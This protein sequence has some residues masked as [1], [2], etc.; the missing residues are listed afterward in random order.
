MERNYKIEKLSVN[1]DGIVNSASLS[2][3]ISDKKDDRLYSKQ[4]L[5]KYSKTEDKNPVE[6]T[7]DLIPGVVNSL[8][9]DLEDEI[10]EIEKHISEREAKEL[11]IEVVVTSE[12]LLNT[13]KN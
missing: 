9:P 6:I 1:I 13:T 7:S 11:G 3:T 12:G 10:L 4:I 2:V 8:F 5:K